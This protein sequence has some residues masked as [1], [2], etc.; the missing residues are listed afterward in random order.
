MISSGHYTSIL[1]TA[2]TRHEKPVEPAS[3]LDTRLSFDDGCLRGRLNAI[4]CYHLHRNLKEPI[5]RIARAYSVN[6]NT[7]HSRIR[8]GRKLIRKSPWKETYIA[9]Q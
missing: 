4:V 9:L 7:I 5:A 1:T 6:W 2:A 3:L 8:T